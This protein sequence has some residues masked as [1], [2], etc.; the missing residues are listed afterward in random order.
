MA[1]GVLGISLGSYPGVNELQPEMQ[2]SPG[3]VSE[4][5]PSGTKLL[6]STL[7]GG[8]GGDNNFGSEVRGMALDPSGDI[9]VTGMTVSQDFPVLNAL[10]PVAGDSLTAPKPAAFVAKISPGQATGITLTRSSLTFPPSP[11]DVSGNA[12]IQAVGLQNNQSTALNISSVTAAAAVF[13]W[14]RL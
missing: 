7:L 12:S 6:L 13:P 4:M 8:S 10:Q 1:G 14:S 2:L 3:F 11:V 5:D 9:Y